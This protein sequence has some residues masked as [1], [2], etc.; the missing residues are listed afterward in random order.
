MEKAKAS[1]PGL[2]HGFSEARIS[3][4]PAVDGGGVDS[5]PFCGFLYGEAAGYQIG[6]GFAY[7]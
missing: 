6:E 1:F 2:V 3:V 5:D 4:L 7:G